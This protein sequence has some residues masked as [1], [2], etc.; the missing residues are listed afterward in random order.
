MARIFPRLLFCV[1]YYIYIV[2]RSTPKFGQAIEE[3][4]PSLCV[5]HGAARS[6]TA[7]ASAR[8][9]QLAFHPNPQLPQSLL[10]LWPR[11]GA[12]R[13]TARRASRVLTWTC[14]VAAPCSA[15]PPDGQ[16]HGRGTK[17]TK[18]TRYVQP[19]PPHRETLYSSH[20]AQRA[21]APRRRWAIP[22]HS[23]EPASQCQAVV[24]AAALPHVLDRPVRP[25]IGPLSDGHAQLPE[26]NDAEL[27]PALCCSVQTALK[28]QRRLAQRCRASW[29]ASHQPSSAAPPA[30]GHT[31]AE[32][33]GAR[34]V[35]GTLS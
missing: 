31:R 35:R 25:P 27:M 23:S 12:P 13:G 8:P 3:S 33:R 17:G 4:K 19:T 18:I 32:V 5:G 24:A 9:P 30:D 15:A 28:S 20:A 11:R 29:W 10:T 7:G 21:R 2:Y 22:R 6:A 16:H 1:A 14:A 34:R 26:A